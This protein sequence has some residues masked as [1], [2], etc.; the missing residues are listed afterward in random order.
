VAGAEGGMEA[1]CCNFEYAHNTVCV[2][3]RMSVCLSISECSNVLALFA[4]VCVCSRACFYFRIVYLRWFLDS[5]TFGPFAAFLLF[6]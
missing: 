3:V 2:Y 4:T 1:R 6:I 5:K